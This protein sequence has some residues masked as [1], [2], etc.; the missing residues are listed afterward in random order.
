MKTTVNRREVQA[1]REE[2]ERVR[3][4]ATWL[5]RVAVRLVGSTLNTHDVIVD[6]FRDKTTSGCRAVERLLHQIE[7]GEDG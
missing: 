1:L 7:L 3:L 5:A 4:H 6:E 2:F